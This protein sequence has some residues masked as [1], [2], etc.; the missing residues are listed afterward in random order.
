MVVRQDLS[1]YCYEFDRMKQ[2]EK[3]ENLL[4]MLPKL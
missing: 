2:I 3:Y 4:L 1:Y